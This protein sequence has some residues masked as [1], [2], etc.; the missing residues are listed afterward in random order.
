[1]TLERRG[2]LRSGFD[3][4]RHWK[5]VVLLTGLT[6]VL[7]LIGA[8]PLGAA[9]QHDLAGTLAGDHFLRNAATLAPGDFFDFLRD[10]RPV[11]GL[12]S[13]PR[14]PSASSPSCNRR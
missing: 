7:G 14:T 1:M 13:E 8:T 6:A 2:S 5:I 12:R 3:A 10:R 11:I 9:F 4:L